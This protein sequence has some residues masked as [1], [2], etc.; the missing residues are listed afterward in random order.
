MANYRPI[1]KVTAPHSSASPLDPV[2]PALDARIRLPISRDRLD[3]GNPDRQNIHISDMI[4]QLS[5]MPHQNGS[6]MGRDIWTIGDHL[7]LA[8]SIY[9]ALCA[10]NM[11]PYSPAIRAALA[12]RDSPSMY[13][14]S[15]LA[16]RRLHLP[17]HSEM[18]DRDWVENRIADAIT[19]KYGL[20][21]P[22]LLGSGAAFLLKDIDNL[23]RD[24]EWIHS[25]PIFAEDGLWTPHPTAAMLTSDR[26]IVRCLS[27]A[28]GLVDG[29]VELHGLY[30]EVA[31]DMDNKTLLREV[32]A[33]NCPY[34]DG[35]WA[36]PDARA[37]GMTGDP[38]CN[39]GAQLSHF[40]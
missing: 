22:A 36:Y 27:S 35:E 37:G 29:W 34:D 11:A 5:R 20:T 31:Y 8:D 25:R 30:G 18:A 9:L 1:Y 33:C 6:T 24:V 21:N 40:G 32:E 4:F 28:G 12:F 26:S 15:F 39:R 13:V 2:R 23:A 38:D 7:Q 17:S 19:A 3:L 14:S 10:R 16:T